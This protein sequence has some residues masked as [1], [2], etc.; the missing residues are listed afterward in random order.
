MCT[1]WDQAMGDR[2]EG[3]AMEAEEDAISGRGGL[4]GNGLGVAGHG[5]EALIGLQN[6]GLGADQGSRG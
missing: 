3:Y 5:C 4:V 1:E 2:E 6:S